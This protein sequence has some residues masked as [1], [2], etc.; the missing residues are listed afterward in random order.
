MLDKATR[1]QVKRHNRRLV[2]R[3]LYH[4]LADSRAG[5][6]NETGL[7]KPTIGTI[8]S[9]LMEQG[10]VEELG[11]GTSSSSGG[12]RPTL[13]RFVASARQ[14]I[15]VS[16]NSEE[17]IAGLAYLDGKLIA[18]HHIDVNEGDDFQRLLQYAINALI[19][20]CDSHL[21]CIGVGVQGVVNDAEGIVMN[22]PVL[23][24]KKYP[25][26]QKLRDK[27][28]V[29]AFI[30]NNTEFTT[31]M[32][33]ASNSNTQQLV[34][35][36]I[37]DSI[38]IGSTFGGGIYQHGGNV[39]L[40]ENIASLEWRNIRAR[41]QALIRAYPDSV[42][43]SRK[44]SFLLLKRGAYL[45]DPA[46]LQL[47]EEIATILTRLYAWIITLMRPSDLVLAGAMSD[48]GD[49]LLELVHGKL[50][51]MLPEAAMQNTRLRRAESQYLSMQ[52]AL[53][54]ALAQEL[55]VL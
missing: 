51:K 24:W 43:A 34:T 5:L 50:R 28:K 4:N 47:L 35:V 53:T 27:Y 21:L 14:V 1:A 3:A 37:G 44:F 31:R 12:K 48:V 36:S 22:S 17:L 39:S 45:K 16:L 25:L 15:G 26:A 33:G 23:G 11:L 18:R 13:L 41:S 9:E 42:L 40:L 46:A 29:P 52:G 10:Y 55:G 6:A 38:E 54:N 8:V 7:T 19:A 2:L 20:Q 32:Y 49:A 30:G